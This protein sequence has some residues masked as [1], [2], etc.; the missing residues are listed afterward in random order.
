MELHLNFYNPAE[1]E[2]QQ[3]CR[4]G[5]LQT[6][7]INKSHTVSSVKMPAQEVGTRATKGL[8]IKKV[9]H[10]L[11]SLCG[12]LTRNLTKAHWHFSEK[13]CFHFSPKENIHPSP[14]SAFGGRVSFSRTDFPTSLSLLPRQTSSPSSKVPTRMR[15][16]HK[17]T[18]SPWA[19]RSQPPRGSSQPFPAHF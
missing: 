2:H 10:K 4:L 9:H 19:P 15:G 5:L 1:S 6:D 16:L 3:K 13:R 7:D 18:A 11:V 12:S 17:S 8:R 14:A